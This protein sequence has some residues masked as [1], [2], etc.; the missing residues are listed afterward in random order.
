VLTLH[1]QSYALPFS[2]LLRGSPWHPGMMLG[3]EFRFTARP[4]G[5]L[6]QTANL[7]SFWAPPIQSAV[8]LSSEFVYRYTLPVG[9]L[10]ELL[11]GP[12]YLHSFSTRPLLERS[13]KGYRQATDWGTAHF[14]LSLAIGAGFDFQRAMG[15][16]LALFVRYQPMFQLPGFLGSPVIPNGLLHLGA[17]YGFGGTL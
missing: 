3:T 5:E 17:R 6:A 1:N 12:A 4:W 16:P 10:V 9:P 11:V 13:S 2:N 7:G 15:V 8:F 14:T